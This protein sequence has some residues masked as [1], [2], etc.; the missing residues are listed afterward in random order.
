MSPVIQE[1]APEKG[2][3]RGRRWLLA[4]LLLPIILLALLLV[5]LV[6]PVSFQVGT[7]VIM[8]ASA[9]APSV[10]TWLAPPGYYSL[11]NRASRQFGTPEGEGFKQSGTMHT[12][13]VRLGDWM[14]GVAWFRGQKLGRIPRR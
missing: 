10:P 11:D 6:R 5:P 8:A 1:Q 12:R 13:G 14:Y 7:T 2:A 3:R 9:Y 4:L